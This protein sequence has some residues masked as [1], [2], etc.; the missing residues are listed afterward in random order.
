MPRSD[1][2]PVLNE[3]TVGARLAGECAIKYALAG[4][5]DRRTA[6]SYGLF[7]T[8]SSIEPGLHQRSSKLLADEIRAMVISDVTRMPVTLHL[9][10]CLQR[11]TRL[12][13]I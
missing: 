7:A 8:S 3:R 6:G 13:L 12:P 10:G 9:D 5:S 4:K 2:T 1:S 11:I